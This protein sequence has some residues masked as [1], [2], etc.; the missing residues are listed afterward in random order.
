M[1]S[2][3]TNNRSFLVTFFLISILYIAGVTALDENLN[4]DIF[5][6]IKFKDILVILSLFLVNIFVRYVRWHFLIKSNEIT[7][8]FV[9]GF[10]F[11][12]SGFAYTAT[13]GKVGELS[14]VIHY[15]SIGVS[16][17]I[18]VSCFIIERFFD[19]IVVL[20]MAS[21]IFLIFPGFRIIAFSIITMIVGIFLFSINLN[22][23]K[24]ICK[25]L[26]KNKKF[27][28]SR[29]TC[30]IYKVLLNINCRINIKDSLI[31]LAFGGVAWACTSFIL[32]YICQIFS[33]NVPPVQ[34]FSVYPI[35]MLSG[36]VSFIPGG[37][38]A[39]EA[40]IVF[41][42]R[43]F[44]TPIPIASTVALLVRF[45]TLWLAMFIGILCTLVSSV[46]ITK[47]SN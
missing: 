15:R 29:F 31:C 10:F 45:S 47:Q 12:T 38:G 13:P 33:V 24:K 2:N 35:A 7:V 9:K 36:A 44:D 11:Y 25:K 19:L 14:R 30:F 37:V 42:L 46:Y 21:T 43:Q 17:D 32:V 39:T 18:V 40:V 34:M 6:M 26:L 3:F 8:S 23:S 5:D 1:K 16:S 28:I 20:L 27:R 22:I 4:I 41:L